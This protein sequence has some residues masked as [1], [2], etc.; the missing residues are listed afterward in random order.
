MT[1]PTASVPWLQK[2]SRS[3]LR[4]SFSFSRRSAQ[5]FL[6][7]KG[8]MIVKAVALVDDDFAAA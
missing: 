1:P 7:D 5:L 4:I 8:R 3:A 2:Q 6:D